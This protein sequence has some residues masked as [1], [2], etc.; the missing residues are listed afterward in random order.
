MWQE[1]KAISILVY[2]ITS[3]FP[4]EERF[5]LVSQIRR[6]AVSIPSNIAEGWG[7]NTNQNLIMFLRNSMGSLCELETQLEIS[8]ELGF[9]NE[10]TFEEIQQRLNLLS[11]QLKKFINS[12]NEKKIL[13][14][15]TIAY[16]AE[17]Q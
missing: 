8:F 15:P 12:I 3:A 16:E 14:E 2:R 10:Q 13:S 11:R 5:G 9:V 17:L 7:R 4:A 1:G 6:S